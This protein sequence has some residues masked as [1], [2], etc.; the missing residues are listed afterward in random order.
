MQC[1][2]GFDTFVRLVTEQS[3]GLDYMTLIADIRQSRG[4]LGPVSRELQRD[5]ELL[6]QVTNDWISQLEALRADANQRA[7]GEPPQ[8]K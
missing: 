7:E 5:P 4:I 2:W 1:E 8:A 3:I 6:T